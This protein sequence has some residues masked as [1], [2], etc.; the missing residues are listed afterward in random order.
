MKK[1]LSI[2][3]A[4]AVFGASPNVLSCRCVDRDCVSVPKTIQAH[5]PQCHP[6]A[7]QAR[8]NDPTHKECC[9][10]CQ[11]EKSAVLVSELSPVSDVCHRNTLVEIRSFADFHAKI[12]CPYFSHGKF[13]ESPPGFFEQHILN[14]TFS[15]RA[16]PQ[17][18]AL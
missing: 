13:P 6:A 2:F 14:T 16:P 4:V 1:Y 15:F 3:I 8:G 9:G 12:H 7:A 17:R 18:Y 10:K 11:I 5:V